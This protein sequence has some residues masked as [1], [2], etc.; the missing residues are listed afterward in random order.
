MASNTTPKKTPLSATSASA[1]RLTPTGTS[2]TRRPA[3]PHTIQSN[4]KPSA[5]A[6]SSAAASVGRS[7]SLRN[8]AGNPIS[9]RAA[10]KKPNSALQRNESE[11]EE[12]R[13]EVASAMADLK[14]QLQLAEQ[15]TLEAK[16]QNDAL[17]ARLDD[18]T[19][20]Q[21]KLEEKVHE[22]EERA[23]ILENEK[24]DLLKQKR[25]LETIYESERAA[26][27][28][29][30][31]VTNAREEELQS[32]IQRLKDSLSQKESKGLSGNDSDFSKGSSSPTLDANHFAPPS[33]TRNNS[34]RNNS[35]L[36]MQKDKIIEELRLELAELQIKLMELENKGGG[37]A[38][39]LERAL[40][41]ARVTN[42]RLMEENESFQTLLMEKTLNG[43][44]TQKAGDAANGRLGSHS[45]LGASL[46]DEL[47][48]VA[49]DDETSTDGDHTRRLELEVERQKAENRALTLYIN[50]IIER[51]LQH[52]GGFESILSTN[53]DEAVP[54]D[55][56]AGAPP[57]PPK[58]KALPP[59][60]PVQQ[61][62]DDAEPQ[63]V[64]QRVKSIAYGGSRSRPRPQSMVPARTAP[65]V[66]ED[67][68]TAPR[69]PL[70]RN[71][72]Q[73]HSMALPRRV[74]TSGEYMPG[75]AAVVSNM[76]RGGDQEDMPMGNRPGIGSPRASFMFNRVPSGPRPTTA[77]ES[78]RRL[79]SSANSVDGSG[80][81][82]ARKQ[83]LDALNGSGE[84]SDNGPSIDTPSPPRSLGSKDD[85]QVLSGNKMRPL[86][87]LNE[88]QKKNNNNR[89]SWIPGQ[90]T[91]WFNNA[92]P[93]SQT[94]APTSNPAP[95]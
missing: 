6:N 65:S 39:D 14:E 44:F 48:A 86:R 95:P 7:R 28:K 32:I 67:P 47:S 75:A 61:E 72:S 5:A 8:A 18:A 69:I 93:G 17:Q 58:D 20:E 76:T 16:R 50:R 55:S 41:E 63:G 84:S 54:T 45:A 87:L 94:T 23:E 13:A 80:S 68:D 33:L 26:V 1:G 3:S 35:K 91:Q 83:A 30:K 34:F 11:D 51:I 4:S 40:M 57:P 77:S 10:V 81:E 15:A 71:Q 89:Q 21:S 24:R 66:T 59:P 52:Q 74:Q 82:N 27:M 88:E 56:G 79:S 64:L 37:R 73:R 29:E 85:R 53:D 92:A 49:E 36:V 12:S 19:K 38:Q 90:I 42:A 60:P 46:A 62:N 70:Q 43:D 9:A 31:D 2:N 25:E 22:D 78:E